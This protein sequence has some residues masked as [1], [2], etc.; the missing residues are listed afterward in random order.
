M[1]TDTTT[2]PVPTSSPGVSRPDPAIEREAYML[3]LDLAELTAVVPRLAG[4]APA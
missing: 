1:T 3:A 4:R 2:S